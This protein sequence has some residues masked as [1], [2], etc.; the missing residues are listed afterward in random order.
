MLLQMSQEI[1]DMIFDFLFTFPRQ[2]AVFLASTCRYLRRFVPQ[3]T[4][5]YFPLSMQARTHHPKMFILRSMHKENFRKYVTPCFQRSHFTPFMRLSEVI[6]VAKRLQYQEPE[7]VQRL[8]WIVPTFSITKFLTKIICCAHKVQG[9]RPFS[10]VKVT[11]LLYDYNRTEFRQNVLDAATLTACY[12]TLV[13]PK[14]VSVNELMLACLHCVRNTNVN[15]LR[16]LHCD[17]S[18]QKHVREN[19]AKIPES[20]DPLLLRVSGLAR[21]LLC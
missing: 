1:I 20:S 17:D 4:P 19:L 13:C 6:E 2:H 9:S 14:K 16:K 10:C 15:L 12:L 18:L 11:Q 7:K 5:A 21:G 8:D 3:Q